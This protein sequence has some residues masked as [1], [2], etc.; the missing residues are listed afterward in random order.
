MS[1][2]KWM[3]ND[4]WVG[5]AIEDSFVMVNIGNGSYVALNETAH[6]IWDALDAPRS[7]AEIE[8]RLTAQ[9][10]VAPEA[11]AAAVTRTLAEMEVQQLARVA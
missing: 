1:D 8:A 5:S 9:F 4:D 10:D 2:A 7:Q 3:R 11:C 6:A